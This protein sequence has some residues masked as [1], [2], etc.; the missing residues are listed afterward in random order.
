LAAARKD[1]GAGKT[2]RKEEAGKL[3]NADENALIWS[4]LEE[5]T[6]TSLFHFSTQTSHNPKIELL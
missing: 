3:R 6:R 4:D 1:D 5:E 2:R